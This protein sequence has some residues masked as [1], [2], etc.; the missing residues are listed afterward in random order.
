MKKLL[1]FL[2]RL[3]SSR[4]HY[5]LNKVRDS[6]LIEIAVPGERW[7]VEFGEDDSVEVERFLSDGVITDVTLDDDEIP[8]KFVV[9]FNDGTEKIFMFPFAFITGMKIIKR[10]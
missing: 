6:I 9:R 8:T 4:I 5:R 1:A 2:N 10:R 3:E 7:E